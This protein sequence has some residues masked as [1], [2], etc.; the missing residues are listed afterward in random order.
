MK[1]SKFKKYISWNAISII[2]YFCIVITFVFLVMLG[3]A[4]S[5]INI[6]AE[7]DE[8]YYDYIIKHIISPYISFYKFQLFLVLI[9]LISS[10]YENRYYIEKS[11]YGLRLFGNH[12]KVYTF[13]F[14]TG[15][16][17]NFLPLYIIYMVT[18]SWI[19]KFI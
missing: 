7:I 18:I 11:E 1:I 5:G 9:F 17:L 2:G 8:Y 12:E 3:I 15:L 13:F 4:M 14:V 10:V 19:I 6:K 16:A